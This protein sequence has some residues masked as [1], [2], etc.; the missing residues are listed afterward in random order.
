MLDD[1][2]L[3]LTGTFVASCAQHKI[4]AQNV[5]T[6]KLRTQKAQIKLQR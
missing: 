4:L 1:R 5:A 2:N 3:R 6:G